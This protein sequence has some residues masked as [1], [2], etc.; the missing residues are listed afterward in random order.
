MPWLR[1]PRAVQVI[2]LLW[3]L[4]LFI[5]V[6]ILCFGGDGAPSLPLA[7]TATGGLALFLFLSTQ[8]FQSGA[9]ADF[10]L[11]RSLLVGLV[12]ALF[13][14]GMQRSSRVL[15]SMEA[16]PYYAVANLLSAYIF[17]GPRWHWPWE[18]LSSRFSQGELLWTQRTSW[19][20]TLA[21]TSFLAVFVIYGRHLVYKHFM[22]PDDLYSVKLLYFYRDR[23]SLDIP[24]HIFT[25]YSRLW[26]PAIVFVCFAGLL[27]YLIKGKKDVKDRTLLLVLVLAAVAGK[28][29]IAYLSTEGLGVLARKIASVHNN[30]YILADG[31]D[32]KGLI[33]YLR[34][35][36]GVQAYL[37]N[38][39]NTHPFGPIVFYWLLI[40][41]LGH[42]PGLIAFAYMALTSLTVWPI[43][44]LARSIYQSRGMGLAAAVLYITTPMSLIL[45]GSGIDAV[46]L[47]I[48]AF[49][50]H[51]LNESVVRQKPTLAILAG[52]I[53]F[54][55]IMI[56]FGVNIT[57]MFAGLWVLWKALT[58]SSGFMDWVL[59]FLKVLLPFGFTI[60][61]LV[62]LLY[63]SLQ[64]QFSFVV[65]M[66]TAFFKHR[67]INDL[68]Y[69]DLWAWANVMVYIGYAGIPVVCLFLLQT[70]K[71]LRSLDWR[72][73]FLT[74]SL[75]LILTF[76]VAA[77]GR[78]EVHRMFIFAL[79]FLLI[80]A[81][82]FL[83]GEPL[84]KKR[85]GQKLSSFELDHSL[86]LALAFLNF[87]GAAVIEM[88]VLDFM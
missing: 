4:A 19:I 5:K 87:A 85:S 30:Y 62:L 9:L 63:V 14:M 69:Y 61:A 44:K 15:F 26:A 29:A 12:P 86:L 78:A 83:K 7:L 57:L 55:N 56:T 51:F 36:N 64:G 32:E 79:P 40:K 60:L 75:P 1:Q 16:M 3:T 33:R 18:K 47:L 52:A 74:L 38:H 70:F 88:T 71:R 84:R 6:E 2:L 8:S 50:L 42:N 43:F 73:A 76:V 24:A 45:S 81:V 59:R 22:T 37:G 80:P 25:E 46:V 17:L 66:K 10:S 54:L 49:S 21:G 35:F 31:I 11:E 27:S 68:R 67:Q 65:V 53:F 77:M 13:I 72:D 39:G 41:L 82:P 23:D 48:W 34:E 58:Q 28:F 20:S